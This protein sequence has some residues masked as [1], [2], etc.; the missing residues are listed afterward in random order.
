MSPRSLLCFCM[1]GIALGA[2]ERRMPTAKLR[3][4]EVLQKATARARTE[5]AR[6]EMANGNLKLLEALGKWRVELRPSLGLFAFSNPMLLAT[7]LG[8]S[9]LLNRRTAP[10]A[11]ALQGARF[12]AL[13]A[14]VQAESLRVR[15]RIEAA[16]CYFDL[17]AKQQMAERAAELLDARR[18][19]RKQVDAM[20]R[21]ARISAVEKLTFEQDLLDLESQWLDAETARKAAAIR[22][23]Q[24]IGSEDSASSIHVED[25]SLLEGNEDAQLRKVGG[26]F[27]QKALMNRGE[28]RLLQ[29]KIAALN[30]QGSRDKKIKVETGGIGYARLANSPGVVSEGAKGVLLGGNTGRSDIGLSISLRDTGEKKAQEQIHAARI[31]VLELE[32]RSL[33]DAIRGEVAALENEVGASS[34]RLALASRRLELAM[35]ADRVAQARVEGGLADPSA[36][37]YSEQRVLA[38]HW[39]EARATNERKATLFTLLTMS[40]LDPQTPAGAI[41]AE[42]A[43]GEQD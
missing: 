35:Q 32:L 8:S 5:D 9:L 34:E 41:A 26:Q 3:F 10:T 6:I 15:T 25:V 17:L 30:R 12:D 38:A 43:V 24:L 27:F 40:G 39:M 7:N 19:G 21:S 11:N 33:E 4:A 22:L 20:I 13:A 36:R 42:T 14:E 29:N 1:A 2:E 37:A 28:I 31:R 23:S 18:Q 16:H